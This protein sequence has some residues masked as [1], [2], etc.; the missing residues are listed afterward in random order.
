M[1][2]AVLGFV[3]EV[4]SCCGVTYKPQNMRFDHPFVLERWSVQTYL[5][6]I[7]GDLL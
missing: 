1:K 5:F 6:S 3:H 4:S 7:I 2:L